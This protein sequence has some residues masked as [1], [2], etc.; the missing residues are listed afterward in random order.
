[1]DKLTPSLSGKTELK[2]ALSELRNNLLFYFENKG[3]DTS[4]NYLSFLT[5]TV[6]NYK[7]GI[8][9]IDKNGIVIG[10]NK[11]FCL[12]FEID[13]KEI[14]GKLFKS[15]YNRNSNEDLEELLVLFKRNLLKPDI[16][17][18]FERF[19]VT[20]NGKSFP[21]EGI[22]T[23]INVEKL[24]SNTSDTLLLTIFND[25]KVSDSSFAVSNLNKPATRLSRD[26]IF[27]IDLFGK[28]NDWNLGAEKIYNY[29][30]NEV[31]GES[32]SIIFSQDRKNEFKKIIHRLIN[33]EIIENFETINIKKDGTLVPVLFQ[34][35]PIKNSNDSLKGFTIIPH[36][37]TEQKNTEIRLR[38]NEEMYRTL[39]E[40]SPDAIILLDLNGKILMGNK[41]VALTLGYESIEEIQLQ[42]IFSFFTI[43]DKKRIFRDTRT[44]IESGILKNREYTVVRKNKEQVPVEISASLILD[45]IGRP[46]SIVGIMRDI[47][48]R[49]K[50]EEE[51]K[52]SELRFRS[53][54]ENSNDGMRLTNC[55]GIIVAVN[56]AYCSLIGLNEE[57]LLGKP[58]TVIFSEEDCENPDA[59]LKEF[60]EKFIQRNISSH[61]QTS[62]KYWKTDTIILLEAYSFIDFEKGESLLL[63]IYHNIT[64]MKRNEEELRN[65]EKFA[66]I[67]KQAA[68]L[69]HE[70]KSPLASIK[71]N[72]DMLFN[73]LSM[74]E[75]NQRS[76][77]IVQKE[78]KRLEVLLK[79]VLLYSRELNLVFLPVDLE[80]LVDN[81]KELMKPVLKKQNILIFNYL[82]NLRFNGDYRNLQTV[83]LHLIENSIES[84]PD[85]GVIE[86][87][88]EFNEKDSFSVFIKDNGSG[89]SEKEKIFDP[90]FTTKSS[91][92]G[93]GL[94][95]ARNIIK[96]HNC[97]LNLISSTPGETI[98]KILFTNNK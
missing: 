72:I 78:I 11:A 26:A 24:F 43:R 71:M 29:S 3:K 92:T 81:I 6:N 80:K 14:I 39:I 55:E 57:D 70:I 37:I 23:F 69:T 10:V 79:N 20:S 97:E 31:I 91:G 16:D 13:E 76:F 64:E 62:S 60:K 61:V 41:H 73:N 1:M 15:I 8:R 52:N 93:L 88:S 75:N 12:L 34:I 66:A 19:I 74:S 32:V 59:F 45:Y 58:F 2:N 95:I 35:T 77:Q 30:A 38:K 87:Y 36:D 63:G 85:G 21:L 94:S 18:Y 46:D 51:I 22:N 47:T 49:K 5:E 4:N 54:W 56:K 33:G 89:I 96:Q 68:M 53:I 98:F 83:F 67:G 86:I 65:A 7:Y 40:T 9:F 28:I 50:A 90:F 27:T 82:T 17:Y 48:E 25:V 84:M 42:N 44:I